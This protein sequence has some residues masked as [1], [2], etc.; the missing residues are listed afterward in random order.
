[1]QATATVKTQNKSEAFVILITFILIGLSIWA[2]YSFLNP[3]FNAALERATLPTSELTKLET[4][5]SIVNDAISETPNLTTAKERAAEEFRKSFGTE[6]TASGPFDLPTT[7]MANEI[8]PRSFT[9]VIEGASKEQCNKLLGLRPNEYDTLAV[10]NLADVDY[11][12]DKCFEHEKNRIAL[13]FKRQLPQS[14]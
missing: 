9:L 8:D 11:P 13:T 10:A 4:I 14:Q 6:Q 5:R 3:A 7:F 1:M 12:R 2:G